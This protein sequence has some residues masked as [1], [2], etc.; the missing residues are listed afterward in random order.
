MSAVAER[1]L[2]RMP[3]GLRS[4]GGR[5]LPLDAER[6]FAEPSAAEHRLLSRTLAPVLDV[7]CGPARHT[8]SLV[9]RGIPALGVDISPAAVRVATGRG[10]PVLHRSV[11]DRLP[12]EGSWGTALLIDGNVGIGGNPVAL[13]TR[14]RRTLRRGGRVLVEVGAPGTPTESFRATIEGADLGSWFPWATVGADALPAVAEGAHLRLRE[15][16]PA[17]GRWFGRLDT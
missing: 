9:A 2:G 13:L 7:G 10:A 6:W 3:V 12:D 4:D 16:W 17:E 14:L 11:F 5:L 8:L 1:M 15:L